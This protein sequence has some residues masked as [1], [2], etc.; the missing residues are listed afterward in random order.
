MAGSRGGPEPDHEC[1]GSR[2]HPQSHP[3]ACVGLRSSAHQIRVADQP[4]AP[5]PAGQTPDHHRV[6]GPPVHRTRR[7]SPEVAP[8]ETHEMCRERGCVAS[9]KGQLLDE[10]V[11]V[12][13]GHGPMPARA[14]STAGKGRGPV[15]AVVRTQRAPTYGYETLRVLQA[16]WA[17][18]G[19]PSGK[20][21]AA[22]MVD[23][24]DQLDAFGELDGPAA[25]EARASWGGSAARSTGRRPQQGG[26]GDQGVPRT[27]KS[28]DK[29]PHRAERNG[30]LVRRHVFRLPLRHQRR[31]GAAQRARTSG[32]AHCPVALPGRV[33][34]P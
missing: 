16:V 6:L 34:R 12:T 33:P 20:Y 27:A 19:M 22:I 2:D 9:G 25:P 23:T 14:V 8:D 10:L 15:R 1:Q 32:M 11:A 3:H 21:L 4:S 26:D 30:D 13:G 5:H 18:M 28:N 17:K 31:A 24:L 29:R 7:T